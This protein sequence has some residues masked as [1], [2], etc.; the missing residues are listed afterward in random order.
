M[1]ETPPQGVLTTRDMNGCQRN[2]SQKHVPESHGFVSVASINSYYT[3]SLQRGSERDRSCVEGERT[4][5]LGNFF[6]RYP[7]SNTVQP[8]VF[9]GNF[10]D[11]RRHSTCSYYFQLAWPEKVIKRGRRPRL[12]LCRW[13]TKT[14]TWYL[15]QYRR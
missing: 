1:S 14:L 13:M 5:V 2:Q 6:V 9:N 11:E 7:S 4:A 8:R 3:Q 10:S 12:N 15:T